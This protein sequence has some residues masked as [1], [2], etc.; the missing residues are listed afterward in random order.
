MEEGGSASLPPPHHL[1]PLLQE[2]GG[3]GANGSAGADERASLFSDVVDYQKGE[4]YILSKPLQCLVIS[5]I[6]VLAVTLNLLVVHNVSACH[7]KQR[8]ANFILIQN[9]CIV[10]AVG[11]ALIL[12]APLAA[13]S[14]G[15]WDFGDAFCTANSVICV[16]LWLQVMHF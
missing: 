12:P 15:R 10:D 11:A 16:A 1:A 2:D 3:A 4:V 8:S 7:F 14:A 13:T 9:L 5:L 6:M